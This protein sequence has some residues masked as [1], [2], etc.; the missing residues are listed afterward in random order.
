MPDR[1]NILF[2]MSDEHRA[3]VT[4]YEGDPVI[5]TPVLDELA[6]TGVVF[7]NAYAPSPIC[8]PARQC[9]MAG[10]LPRTCGCEVYGQDLTP[11]YLTFARQFANH[12]YSTVASGKLHHYG[13][14]QMQGWTKRPVGDLEV[15]P[16]FV[17][18]GRRPPA[19]G[20]NG[21]RPGPGAFDPASVTGMSGR[22][23]SF[24][25]SDAK[26]IKRAGVAYGHNLERDDMAVEGALFAIRGHFLHPFYDR[27][28]LQRPMMLKVS[29]LQPHYPYFTDQERFEY[30]LNRVRPFTDQQ[31]FD[32]PFLSRRAVTPGVDAD[33]REIRRAVAAYY[34]MVETIDDHYGTVMDALEHAGQDL[35]DW[36]IIYTSDHGEMLG[37][38]GVWE[39]QKF[40]EASAR[41]PLIIRWPKRFAGGTTV[42]QNVNLCDLYATLCDLAGLPT[43]PGLDSRSLISLMEGDASNWDNETIS[44]FGPTNL[45]IKRDHLKYQYYGEEMPEVLFDLAA[46]PGETVNAIND[47]AYAAQVA[48]FR[49]RLGTLGFGP[50]ADPG[51]VNAGYGGTA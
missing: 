14:D 39:K 21:G 22:L 43:P 5:R 28:T 7:S 33:E 38:H 35:N 40:F 44:Q 26:E 32:H 47:P 12:G 19:R 31:V 29:L 2:L 18:G 36:I 42:T 37:E 27:A 4:G 48:A 51:Y 46:N 1:P 45:M 11:E 10:Q 6:S 20:G 30:Y 34:G 24:K 3:D 13:W 8:I 9:M 41:V 23:P 25:W 49:V 17:A 16:H 15:G 50:N